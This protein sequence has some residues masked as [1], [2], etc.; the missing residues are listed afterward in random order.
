TSSTIF[1][2]TPNLLQTGGLIPDFSSF[3]TLQLAPN[4][5]TGSILLF[6]AEIDAGTPVGTQIDALFAISGGT[7][8]ANPGVAAQEYFVV[9]VTAPSA[10]PEPGTLLLLPFGLA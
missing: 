8:P 3:T 7:D 10:A 5:A 2:V 4:A 6:T 1:L 9:K